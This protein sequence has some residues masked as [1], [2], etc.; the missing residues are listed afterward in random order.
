MAVQITVGC[1][2]P[3]G[4]HLDVG[5]VRVSVK[6][7][8]ASS[9]VGGHGITPGVDKAFFDAWLAV[10]KDSAVVKKGL[11]FAHEKENSAQAM[12]KERARN[13]SGLEGIDPN[14]P[15]PGIKPASTKADD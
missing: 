9:L 4:L 1:K 7:T 11:I 10:H 3:N 8:N 6:G 14:K 12:A 13:K 2:L 15:A 5:G